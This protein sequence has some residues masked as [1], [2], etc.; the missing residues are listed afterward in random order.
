MLLM[1]KTWLLVSFAPIT[2]SM[3]PANNIPIFC[4]RMVQDTKKI[5]TALWAGAEAVYQVHGP[6]L[7]SVCSFLLP[8]QW[9]FLFL[10]RSGNLEGLLLKPFTE[11]PLSSSWRVLNS[12]K[13]DLTL[14]G[15]H[16]HFMCY[17]GF[18]W[19]SWS[20][21]VFRQACRCESLKWAWACC[22]LPD[23]PLVQI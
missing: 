16:T 7:P 23:F 4:S 20:R 1:G 21:T 8:S 5:L 17:P 3:L 11:Q 6:K 9:L 12:W 19:C 18:M 15:Y 22:S 2:S 13:L 10:Q 14:P